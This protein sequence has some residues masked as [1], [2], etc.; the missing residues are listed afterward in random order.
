[1]VSRTLEER[2][3]QA[4]EAV[5]DTRWWVLLYNY[6]I[7]AA[8]LLLLMFSL[9]FVIMFVSERVHLPITIHFFIVYAFLVL[10]SIILNMFIRWLF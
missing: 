1:M 3:A 7:E 10:W 9:S 5:R 8:L 2:L 4:K 6:C